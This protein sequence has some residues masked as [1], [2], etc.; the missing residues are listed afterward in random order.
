MCVWGGGARACCGWACL[1]HLYE[2]VFCAVHQ[3][4][5]PPSCSL[6]HTMHPHTTPPPAGSPAG[7][8][9]QQGRGSA[10][11]GAV[12][13]CHQ[14]LLRL[15]Q[16]TP[17]VCVCAVSRDC[18]CSHCALCVHCACIGCALGVHF[19]CIVRALG[20]HWVCIGCALGVHWV[21]IG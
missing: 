9:P 18:L 8:A 17:Q 4:V 13:E 1:S 10:A 21:C 20:V 6:Q 2:M 14:A 3:V 15:Q 5:C 7:R 11:Q 12:P 19:A 16:R